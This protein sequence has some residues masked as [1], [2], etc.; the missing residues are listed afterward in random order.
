MLSVQDIEAPPAARDCVW[1]SPACSDDS[2]VFCQGGLHA[3]ELAQDF[4]KL[5]QWDRPSLTSC[6]PQPAGSASQN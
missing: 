3:G 5:E 2:R 6:C 4:G 1:G